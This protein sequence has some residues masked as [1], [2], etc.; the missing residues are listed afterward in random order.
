LFVF[1]L[2]LPEELNCSSRIVFP[3]EVQKSCVRGE[4][5]QILSALFLSLSYLNVSVSASGTWNK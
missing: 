4:V 1:P 3:W 2:C 5:G